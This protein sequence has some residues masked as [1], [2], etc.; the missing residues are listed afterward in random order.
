MIEHA[1]DRLIDALAQPPA[2]R[3]SLV[4]AQGRK[5]IDSRDA[6]KRFVASGKD[7]ALEFTDYDHATIVAAVRASNEGLHEVERD[8]RRVVVAIVR[9]DAIGW[10]YV[11]E[12]DASTL[13]AR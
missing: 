6:G 5:I 9:L 10:S 11:V 13:G 8:G 1:T 3:T 2:L 12:A 7:E 4:D